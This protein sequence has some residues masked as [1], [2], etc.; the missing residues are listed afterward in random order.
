MIRGGSC[1][2]TQNAT[3]LES[4][5]VCVGKYGPECDETDSKVHLQSD[6]LVRQRQ[7]RRPGWVLI[8]RWENSR[9][10]GGPSRRIEG[11]LEDPHPVTPQA[12]AMGHLAKRSNTTAESPGPD[13]SWLLR[14]K[15]L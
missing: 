5:G 15:G 9:L 8:T 14:T 11:A 13:K 3:G 2:T 4:D 7:P 10:R 12:L 1:P 6:H